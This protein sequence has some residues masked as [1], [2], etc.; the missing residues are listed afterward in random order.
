MTLHLYNPGI[1][2]S[3]GDGNVLIVGRT[4]ELLEKLKSLEHCI[5]ISYATILYY[6]FMLPIEQAKAHKSAIRNNNFMPLFDAAIS[7]LC[8]PSSRLL[9]LSI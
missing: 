8:T 2:S 3:E 5:F 7:T 1:D 6:Q 9:S 4:L